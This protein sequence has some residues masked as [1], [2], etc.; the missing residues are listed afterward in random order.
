MAVSFTASGKLHLVQRTLIIGT[1]LT[2]A[3]RAISKT[4][5]KR[6]GTACAVAA[7]DVLIAECLGI[8]G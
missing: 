6:L 2:M 4:R 1:I 5:M 3:A 7:E 8:F